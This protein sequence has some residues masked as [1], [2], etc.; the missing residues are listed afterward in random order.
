MVDRGNAVSETAY[1]L[2]LSVLGTSQNSGKTVTCIG[3]LC[4]LLAPPYN[5]G[6]ADVGYMK[7]VGQRAA[8]L[9]T[10]SGS[11]LVA[12]RDALLVTA[13]MGVDRPRYD[14]I[15]PILW[16]TGRTSACIDDACRTGASNMRSAHIQAVQ[17]AYRALAR[18]KRAMIIEG[19]GQIGV[20]SVGGI[21]AADTV[22]ALRAL[23]APVRVLLVTS[24][25][26]LRS[27]DETVPHLLALARLGVCVDG[28]IVNR[29]DPKRLAEATAILETYYGCILPTLYG[30]R[31]SAD[32]CISVLGLVPE[33]PDLALPTMRLLRDHFA[34]K[35]EANLRTHAWPRHA[36]PERTLVRRTVALS[37]RN[38]FLP[39]LRE[40]DLVVAGINANRRI[41]SLLDHQSALRRTGQMGLAGIILSCQAVGGLLPRTRAYLARGE[42]P[43]I[44]VDLDTATVVEEIGSLNVKIQPYDLAKR[45][46]IAGAYCHHVGMLPGDIPTSDPLQ[47]SDDGNTVTWSVPPCSCPVCHGL[48]D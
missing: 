19:T 26:P 11:P 39:L 12:E 1:P 35:P 48:A 5:L 15:S 10:Q 25:D 33:M 9:P 42:T 3:L 36:D 38:R 22:M 30:Q 46:L 27:I 23:G 18:G 28:L 40:G 8:F 37:L 21:S 6:L 13:L 24:G 7:P 44:A 41:I 16:L 32:G 14:L 17:D 4:K 45:D 47:L 34:S 31:C 43:V 20:G 2:T 29:I